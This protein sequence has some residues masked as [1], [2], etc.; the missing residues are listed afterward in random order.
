[1]FL[2]IDTE[3]GGLTTDYSLLTVAAAIADDNFNIIDKICFGV[4]PPVYIIDPESIRVNKINLVEHAVSSM[5]Q[6][7]AAKELTLFL[8]KGVLLNDN[9]RLI[10][11]GHN[12]AFDLQFIW[13]NLISQQTW[14]TYCAYPAFDTA[15]VARFYTISNTIPNFCGLVALRQLFK[16]ETGDAHNAMA[17]VLATI[18]L[19]KK[20]VAISKGEPALC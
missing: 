3:T 13:H 16:I 9:R 6:E 18:E 4:K 20:F 7:M 17:D 15:A 2:F 1:M 14:N 11:V 10:P 5:S 19:A 8:Q 12:V